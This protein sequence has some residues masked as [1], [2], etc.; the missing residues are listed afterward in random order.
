MVRIGVLSLL[1]FVAYGVSAQ[2]DPTAPLDWTKGKTTPVKRVY[3]HVP[4]LQS[5]VCE[6]DSNH[7]RAIIN[8]TRVKKGD[9]VNGYQVSSINRDNVVL[10]RGS[11]RWNLELFTSIKN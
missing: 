10:M 7:C 8:N 9:S 4:T 2:E 11:K 6:D 5:I 1:L 3:Y